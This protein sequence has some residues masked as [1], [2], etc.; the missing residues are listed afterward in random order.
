MPKPHPVQL[1][2]AP[3]VIL[4]GTLFLPEGSPRRVIALNGA[5]GVPH[6]YYA[7]FAAW[8]CETEQ[9]VVLTYDYRDFGASAGGSLRTSRATMA[10]WGFGDQSAAADFLLETYPDLPLWVIGHS[11]GGLFVPFYAQAERVERVIAVASGPAHWTGHPLHYLPTVLLFWW[12]LGPLATALLGYT[13]GRLL[14]FGSDL[15][16]GVFW[17]WRRW[18][19][20]Q[21]FYRPDWGGALPQ[22]R[23]EAVRC[24]VTLVSVSDDVMLPPKTVA[25]LQNFYPNADVD[26][27]TI[28][29]ASIGARQIGHI[30]LF[31]DRNAAAW[32]SILAV[33]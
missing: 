6:G 25:R 12:V 11:L 27:R 22:P 28:T 1:S 16:K 26:H 19:L 23:F 7:R 2:S 17:Q 5:T 31:A 8:L 21:R 13:P 10:D 32:P 15:P 33:A 18:C 29:P 3:G 4:N 30:R 20:S 14:G 24:P 9:A